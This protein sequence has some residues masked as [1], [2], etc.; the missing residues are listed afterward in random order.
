MAVL[1]MPLS[2][3][4]A[5]VLAVIANHDGPGGARPSLARIAREAGLKHRARAAETVAELEGLGV[6]KRRRG[7]HA[8]TYEIIYAWRPQCPGKPDSETVAPDCPGKPDG[9]GDAPT[10]HSVRDSRATVSAN[11]GHEPE[12][13]EGTAPAP[14]GRGAVPSPDPST[15]SVA[16]R[17]GE[18][19]EPDAD[20][21]PWRLPLVRTID[22]GR[23]DTP[24]E[25]QQG[26]GGRADLEATVKRLRASLPTDDPSWRARG[27]MQTQRLDAVLASLGEAMLAKPRDDL[28]ESARPPG[29]PCSTDLG[30]SL[31]R[32]GNSRLRRRAVGEHGGTQ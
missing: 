8:N 27:G 21:P 29:D 1:A 17:E 12:E 15:E 16:V 31:D 32:H 10:H 23:A 4:Q 19:T 26:D 18:P 9:V 28:E 2:H 13:P 22:G 5:R 3:R 7:K 11:P 6:L 24:K 25:G 14:P 20:A 30:A